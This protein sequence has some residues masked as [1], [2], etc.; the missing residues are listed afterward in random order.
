MIE[1]QNIHLTFNHG[2]PMETQ[3]LR[4]VDLTIAAG[5][6]VTNPEHL[7]KL[8]K[9]AP[10]HWERGNLQ[11]VLATDVIRGSSGPPIVLA[12]HFWQ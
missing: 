2:T 6:F 4:G 11:A 5:E 9:L 7:A 1:L 3:S 12:T 8:E 10:A